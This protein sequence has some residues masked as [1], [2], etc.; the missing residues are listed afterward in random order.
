MLKLTNIAI[1]TCHRYLGLLAC[2]ARAIFRCISISSSCFCSMPSKPLNPVASTKPCFPRCVLELICGI[3]INS[4]LLE[5]N[6]MGGVIITIKV[7]VIVSYGIVT[8]VNL[9]RKSEKWCWISY[10]EMHKQLA[11]RSVTLTTTSASTPFFLRAM[12]SL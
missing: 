6:G 8:A 12:G 10:L 2:S 11:K 4:I 5:S 3:S 1:V 7:I 9:R